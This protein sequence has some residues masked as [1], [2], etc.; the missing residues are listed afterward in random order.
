[1]AIMCFFQMMHLSGFVGLLSGFVVFLSGFVAFFVRFWWGYV[2]TYKH[3][4]RPQTKSTW[5][6]IPELKAFRVGRVDVR[7]EGWFR[8]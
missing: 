3:L 2:C 5:T 1:M 4:K 8:V 6:Q 7:Y